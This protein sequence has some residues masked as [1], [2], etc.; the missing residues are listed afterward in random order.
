MN[1]AVTLIH[2]FARLLSLAI[3]VNVVLSYFMS[4]YHPVRMALERVVRPVL[5]PLRK[6]IPPVGMM[7]ISPIVAIV[8]IQV[9][10][11]LLTNLLLSSR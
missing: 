11:T 2:W 6:V 10:E 1:I 8:L 3:I 5:A 9:L 4:P 7:D